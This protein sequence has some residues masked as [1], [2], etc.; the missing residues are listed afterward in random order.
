LGALR[1][2]VVLVT[3]DNPF[4]LPIL[5]IVCHVNGLCQFDGKLVQLSEETVAVHRSILLLEPTQYAAKHEA[6]PDLKA[7]PH[8]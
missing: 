7:L 8:W 5:Q 6:Y 2:V 4:N 3:I 1:E